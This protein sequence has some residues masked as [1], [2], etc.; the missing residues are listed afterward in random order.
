MTSNRSEATL[1]GGTGGSYTAPAASGQQRLWIIDRLQTRGT[2]TYNIPMGKALLGI[3]LI[4]AYGPT[5][6]A[7]AVSCWLGRV[8]A[9]ELRGRLK[10]SL[11]D[12]ME[13]VTAHCDEPFSAPP[14]PDAI[15]PG[16]TL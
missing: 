13:A 3:D 10:R 6:A 12:Y 16:S 4:C 7:I 11:P 1:R 14:R 8:D 9:D 2:P 5:E 15:G